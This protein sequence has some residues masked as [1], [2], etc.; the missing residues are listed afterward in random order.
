MSRFVV[1][2]LWWGGELWKRKIWCN[3]TVPNPVAVFCD[4]RPV[5]SGSCLAPLACAL[6]VSSQSGLLGEQQRDPLA[7]ES[8]LLQYHSDRLETPRKSQHPAREP[9]GMPTTI[10]GRCHNSGTLCQISSGI[11]EWVPQSPRT[12]FCVSRFRMHPHRPP[13]PIR[14][15]GPHPHNADRHVHMDEADAEQFTGLLTRVV[16]QQVFLT[17]GAHRMKLALLLDPQLPSVIAD[18][19]KWLYT[20]HSVMKLLL[21]II[22]ECLEVDMG[23]VCLSGALRAGSPV[24]PMLLRC[25][26]DQNSCDIYLA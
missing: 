7:G 16:E 3:K 15:H 18:L 2:V 21:H 26:S 25:L 4:L 24:C 14:Y 11:S 13:P 1:V 19:H 6:R 17:R 10:H 23:K 20:R 9:Q 22:D 8:G 5:S 12:A